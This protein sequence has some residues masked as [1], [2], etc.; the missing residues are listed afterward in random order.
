[1]NREDEIREIK[2]DILCL[3]AQVIMCHEKEQRIK[4]EIKKLK[5]RLQ[6]LIT[7]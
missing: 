7:G 1:M 4:I 6:V 5:E 3:N 2:E